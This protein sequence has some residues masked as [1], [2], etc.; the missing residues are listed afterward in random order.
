[1]KKIRKKETLCTEIK[2]ITGYSHSKSSAIELYEKQS[3]FFLSHVVRFLGKYELYHPFIYMHVYID[4]CVV[5]QNDK[6]NERKNKNVQ[7]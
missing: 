2:S 5:K 1:M 6:K 3:F 7:I 4:V